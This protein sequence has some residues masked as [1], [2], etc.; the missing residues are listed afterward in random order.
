MFSRRRKLPFQT[1]LQLLLR[2][3]VKSLQVVLNEWSNFIEWQISASAY[4]Q[5]RKKFRH[6]AFIELHQKCVLEVMYGDDDF[7]K[8]K[9][10][11]LL[12]LDG[13]TLRIPSNK[14]TRDYFGVV[15]YVNG[16]KVRERNQAEAK[17]TV[18][19]D[20]LNNIAV[21]AKLS[22]ARTNDIKASKAHLEDLRVGDVIIAD[23]A[24]GSYR[25]FAEIKGANA[26]FIVRCKSKTFGKYHQLAENADCFDTTVA[27]SPCDYVK[28]GQEAESMLVRFLKITL[29]S[30]EEEILA[31]SLLDSQLFSVE[32]F[33]DLYRRRWSIETYFHTLKSRLCLD[34]FTG[35]SVENVFQDFYSTIFVSGME[36]MLTADANEQL[37]QKNTRH[38][39]KVNKAVSFN[40]IKNSFVR[41]MFEQP[42]DFELRMTKLF[43][44]NPVSI[45]PHRIKAPRNPADVNTVRPLNFQRY[46][47]KHVF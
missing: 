20:V 40:V 10:H 23:R 35:H 14:E 8:F 47:R 39:L 29:P 38:P 6:S 7:A 27:I 11:R 18:L 30:G 22:P 1:V 34:N 13:S 31:T 19:Y 32:E 36:T 16:K 37:M 9:G 28:Q 43:M 45:R 44:L 46:A 42:P 5:A 33:Q 15:K 21:S 25:F 24:F 17:M 12:A 3:S 4:S 2:K 41:L 26:D